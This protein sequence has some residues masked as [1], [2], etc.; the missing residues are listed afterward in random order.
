MS[1]V[2]FFANCKK[3]SCS[4]CFEQKERWGQFSYTV[5]NG[6]EIYIYIFLWGSRSFLGGGLFKAIL[7]SVFCDIGVGA[8]L[9]LRSQ[10]RVY[11]ITHCISNHYRMFP[12]GFPNFTHDSL[13][14][15][16]FDFESSGVFKFYSCAK[17]ILNFFNVVC[18][19]VLYLFHPC[20]TQKQW[21]RLCSD[22]AK[23]ITKPL[24]KASHGPRR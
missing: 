21:N 16:S 19:L 14:C 23:A 4:F 2:R 1:G 20:I 3:L 12:L 22:W 11:N 18:K 5:L 8:S 9:P 15:R 24:D 7:I 10:P 17:H 13:P 6:K